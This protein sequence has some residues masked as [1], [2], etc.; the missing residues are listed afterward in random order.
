MWSASE[1]GLHRQTNS[2][3]LFHMKRKKNSVQNTL[4]DSKVEMINPLAP[5][6]D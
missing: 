4:I 3:R 5:K 2:P 6:S 1:K